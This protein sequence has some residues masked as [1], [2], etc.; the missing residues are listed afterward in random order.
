MPPPTK[1]CIKLTLHYF[2][3]LKN[4]RM[5]LYIGDIISIQQQLTFEEK[6]KFIHETLAPELYKVSFSLSR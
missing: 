3:A 2:R 5:H 1:F 6:S 4:A